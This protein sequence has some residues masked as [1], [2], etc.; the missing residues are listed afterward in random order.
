M[1]HAD[2]RSLSD[3]DLIHASAST[4]MEDALGAGGCLGGILV[5]LLLF[6]GQLA[7]GSA[8]LPFVGGLALVVAA[9]A[10]AHRVISWSKRPLREELEYRCGQAQFSRYV[11]EAEA[12]LKRGE[13]DWIVLLSSRGLPHGD[14]R[15]MRLLV[16]KEFSVRSDLRVWEPEQRILQ[17]V[18][19]NVPDAIAQELLG[20]LKA[21]D[22]ASLTDAPVAVKDGTP[23]QLAILRREPWA[24]AVAHC[25]LGG[26]YFGQ[27]EH[28]TMRACF[29]LHDLAWRRLWS[30]PADG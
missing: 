17:R 9:V 14:F 12:A 30:D 3:E 10:I 4:P 15:W 6:V 18:E 27:T 7:F 28:P 21:C 29:A 26:F 2:P 20:L 22:L 23:C 25:N 24:A 1:L 16:R 11:E 13:A 8:A 19:T 5:V